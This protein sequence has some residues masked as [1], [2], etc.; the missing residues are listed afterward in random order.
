M[1]RVRILAVGLLLSVAVAASAQ[2]SAL[3]NDPVIAA[4]AARAT[5]FL[6]SVSGG[7]TQN[8]YQD[9]LA[10]SPLAKQTDALKALVGRTVELEPK[11][12]RYRGCERI[13]ARRIGADVVLMKYLYKCD[14]YPVIWYFT[15]YRTPAPGDLSPEDDTWRVIALR[16]DTELDTLWY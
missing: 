8:A 14:N 16:F 11:Y 10:G 13:G 5:Q 6:D 15:F 2:E 12:G 4:L 7:Q 3:Q 9:L 1:Y